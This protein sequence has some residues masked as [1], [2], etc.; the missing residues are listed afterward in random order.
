MGRWFLDPEAPVEGYTF[1]EQYR[2]VAR[3]GL[4]QVYKGTSLVSS[5]SDMPVSNYK[6]Y[7]GI[8][9]GCRLQS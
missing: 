7:Y 6:N 3:P 4:L 9:T 5:A 1:D 8:Y 2:I